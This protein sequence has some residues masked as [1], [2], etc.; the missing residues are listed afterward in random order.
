M[1]A[2]YI[3]NNFIGVFWEL[4]L[5]E[6]NDPFLNNIFGFFGQLFPIMFSQP[7]SNYI[8][9]LLRNEYRIF[10]D[11]W[12]FFVIFFDEDLGGYLYNLKLGIVYLWSDIFIH[13]NGI[14]NRF[15]NIFFN[16]DLDR[17]LYGCY[18]LDWNF[19]LNNHLYWNFN[20]QYYFFYHLY[21][22]LHDNFYWNLNWQ[23]CL[24]F[25]LL[26]FI[27]TFLIGFRMINGFLCWF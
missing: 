18:F 2:Q 3:L 5:I 14:D 22:P 12:W 4:F 23:Y 17:Y 1:I 25:P 20:W 24:F 9:W 8:L 19:D 7:F 15:R 6:F 10:D 21:L 27:G 13:F 11:I 16:H 26:F